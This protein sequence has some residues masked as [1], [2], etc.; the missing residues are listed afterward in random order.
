M[1][2]IWIYNAKGQREHKL[3]R[4]KPKGKDRT[5]SSFNYTNDLSN[6]LVDNKIFKSFIVILIIPKNQI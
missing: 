2:P 4:L 5:V 3:C 6:N 1:Y